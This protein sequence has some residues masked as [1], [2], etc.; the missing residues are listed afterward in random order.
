MSLEKMSTRVY[1]GSACWKS[2]KIEVTFGYSPS[3]SREVVRRCP[4]SKPIS[5]SPP[6]ARHN[7][8]W[9]SALAPRARAVSLKV[10]AG[11][12]AT[13]EASA[14][15]GFHCRVRMANR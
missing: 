11:T 5:P 14:W 9:T 10:R 8:R 12:S 13:D 7:A 2:S 3:S 1:Q 6:P 4:A 15:S